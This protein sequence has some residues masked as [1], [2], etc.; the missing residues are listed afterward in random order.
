MERLDGTDGS[1]GDQGKERQAVW[2][3]IHIIPLPENGTNVMNYDVTIYRTGGEGRRPSGKWEMWQQH[4]WPPFLPSFRPLRRGVV[5]GGAAVAV[6]LPYRNF[7]ARA[8]S[9][10]P[11][12]PL[13]LSDSLATPRAALASGQLHNSRPF[14]AKPSEKK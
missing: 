10:C 8:R 12:E 2:G 7:V 9:F 11:S 14:G 13:P 3:F 6:I 5:G 4:S 1:L